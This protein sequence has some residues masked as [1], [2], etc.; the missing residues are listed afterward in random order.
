MSEICAGLEEVLF[1]D[2]SG[3]E[4]SHFGARGRLV[5]RDE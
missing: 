3:D 2:S 5:K 1:S 4:Y